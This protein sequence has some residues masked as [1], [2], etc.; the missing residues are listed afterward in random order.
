MSRSLATVVSGGYGFT[1][2]PR[3]P[4]GYTPPRLLSPMLTIRPEQ[5]A[6]MRAE[7]E[8][9][10]VERLTDRI[11]RTYPR[12]VDGLERERVRERVLAEMDAARD[13]GL[14]SDASLADYVGLAFDLGAEFDRHPLV[15]PRLQDAAIP[16]DQRLRALVRGLSAALWRR[17]RRDL[18]RGGERS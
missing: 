13:Y 17:V 12:A 3:S 16:P 9:Q 10:F 5:I 11:I 6:V 4:P 7:L 14:A 18:A 8:R 1:G 2:P 15:R